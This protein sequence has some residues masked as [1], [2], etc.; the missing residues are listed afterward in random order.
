[1]VNRIVVGILTI[2]TGVLLAVGPQTLFKICEQSHHEGHSVCYWTAQ[3]TIGIGIVLA[4]LGLLYVVFSDPGVRVGLSIGIASL[5]VLTFL[6]ANVLI[7][8]EDSA[9]MPCRLATLPAL[10]IISVLAFALSAVNAGYLLR[11]LRGRPDAALALA[12]AAG[13]VEVAGASAS[14][15]AP[16][17]DEPGAASASGTAA[18]GA[19]APGAADASTETDNGVQ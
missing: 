11:L 15:G 9:M 16:G 2:I 3:A 1:M 5:L 8:V 10:N 19:A 18:P 12:A 17:A 13:A 14:L 7:G 6:I 4:L